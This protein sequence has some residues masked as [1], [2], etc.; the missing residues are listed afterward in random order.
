[1][2]AEIDLD[3]YGSGRSAAAGLA[4]EL[5]AAAT[6]GMLGTWGHSAI[7]AGIVKTVATVAGTP[8][9]YLCLAD[10]ET[11]VLKLR[12]GSGAFAGLVGY[13]CPTGHGLSGRL[14][15]PEQR[16]PISEQAALS[17]Q[18]E[19]VV[20]AGVTA[21]VE[22]PLGAG[23]LTGVI[24]AGLTAAGQDFSPQ[25]LVSMAQL[26]QLAA[27]KLENDQ[28]NTFAQS[29]LRERQ[30][31]EEELR[32]L[33][34]W[35]QR[36]EDELRRSRAET[37]ARLA[38]AAEFRN[39]E[40]A[41]H[42]ERMSRY[43]AT[44]AA[45]IGLSEERVELIRAASTL[46]DI[47]KIAIPDNVLLKP[48]PLSDEE[49][50]VM[51]RHAEIGNDL[52]SGSSSEVLE[53]AA[54]VAL[55]H[56]ERFDGSG[57][58]HGLAGERIPVEGRIAA[59]ADVFDALISD[60]VYRPALPLHKALVIMR[61]GRGSHFDPEI[62]DLF[63]DSIHA[64]EA[65]AAALPPPAS[66]AVGE[67]GSLQREGQSRARRSE[68]ARAGQPLANLDDEPPQKRRSGDEVLDPERLREACGEALRI[69]DKVGDGREAI[70]LAIAQLAR[71]WDGKLIASVYL[72]EHDRLWVIS[73][74]GYSD[75]VHDGFPLDQGVM[76]R[77]VRT[78]QT[79]FVADVSTDTDFVA[80]ASGLVS[81]VA[82]PFPAETPAGVFNL[83][84]VGMALPAEA[85]TLFDP[86]V[87]ALSV[88][89]E[90]MREGLGLDIA[91]LARLC[92][93]AGQGGGGSSCPA[94]RRSPNSRPGRSAAC[95]SSNR[96]SSP[97]EAPTARRRSRATGAAPTASS[98]HSTWAR[99]SCS[100]GAEP[101]TRR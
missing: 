42:V 92:V 80:A 33:I 75:V 27:L 77:A 45:R 24:G 19:A 40:T 21:L 48:G 68:P 95:C 41:V 31:V 4:P 100:T 73:Q 85:A 35:L 66:F 43:C 60:R 11:G 51:M 96:P 87:A 70:D 46:H 79:Q 89:L 29:E 32:D 17:G 76:A 84:T 6:R 86:F 59:V 57:Y 3:R 64:L 82:V 98:S 81:E 52:L 28:L 65:P 101:Q 90:T 18:C 13:E 74:R 58:P 1:M 50:R 78:G 20:E 16:A 67:P 23:G 63:L 56:H 72:L 53:L 30:R 25:Q 71:G 5:L 47:G 7:V 54:L 22:L 94:P 2:K 34:V 49:R 61:E 97:S 37:I 12:S 99:S 55:T 38:H 36:S 93:L 91:S 26:A 14:E 9:A 10:P 39:L 69:L 83:E 8:H 62:L 88:R 44:V 15:P